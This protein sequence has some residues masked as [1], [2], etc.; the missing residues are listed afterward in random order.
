MKKINNKINLN[1]QSGF[2]IADFLFSF[3]LVIS[4]GIIIFALTFSLATVEIS[5]YIVW[6]TARNYSAGNTS[7]A[8]AKTQATLKFNNLADQFPL[9][10]ARGATS[11][12]WFVLN[13]LAIGDLANTSG[14]DNDLRTKLA[15]DRD[16]KDQA[17]EY[18]QPWTGAKADLQLK[19]LSGIKVPFLGPIAA[20][21]TAFTFPVRAFIIRHPSQAECYDFYSGAKRFSQGIQKLESQMNSLGSS[22]SYVV[23]EDNGC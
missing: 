13:G 17:G 23:M 8:D 16:N 1:N 3:V 14:G 15:S 10:T 2:I 7:E 20:D 12:P 4:C 6:S 19:L 21:K 18:R 22:G 11:S 5:Q 9:L